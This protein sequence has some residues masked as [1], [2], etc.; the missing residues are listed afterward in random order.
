MSKNNRDNK[1]N[2]K[3]IV[4]AIGSIAFTMF[5]SYHISIILFGDNSIEVYSSLKDKKVYLESEITRLQKE[6]ANLQ[7]EYFELKNL[8]PEQ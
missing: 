8:E 7:K 5:L 1:I 3:F 2:K 4:L 6:N